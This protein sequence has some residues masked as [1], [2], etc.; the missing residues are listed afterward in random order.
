MKHEKPGLVVTHVFMNAN[1]RYGVTNDPVVQIA[2][3]GVAGTPRRSVVPVKKPKH[4]KK[5]KL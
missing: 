3:G 5:R 2:S 1:W 4:P